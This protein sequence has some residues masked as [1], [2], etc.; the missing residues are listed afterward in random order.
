MEHRDAR[1]PFDDNAPHHSALDQDPGYER[2]GS[3]A[4]D[5]STS[6]VLGAA[7]AG[8][9]ASAFTGPMGM[10]LCAAAGAFVAGY[11][12]NAIAAAIDVRQNDAYWQRRLAEE[13]RRE[14][15]QPASAGRPLQPG[16]E[17]SMGGARMTEREA[18][19]TLS[20]R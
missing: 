13:A 1:L 15:R 5:V 4:A 7:A 12:G 11:A 17:P 8:A 9:L 16:L 14:L 18:A 19:G 20:V 6:A 10:A 3:R 2:A